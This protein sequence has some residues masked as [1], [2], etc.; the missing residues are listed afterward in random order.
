MKNIA[1]KGENVTCRFPDE[2]KVIAS[3]IAETET[4]VNIEYIDDSL[5]QRLWVP[6]SFTIALKGKSTPQPVS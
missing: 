5:V 1:T 3:K 2:T 6:A 4:H